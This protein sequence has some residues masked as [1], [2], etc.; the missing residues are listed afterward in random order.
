MS[1]YSRHNFKTMTFVSYKHDQP[2]NMLFDLVVSLVVV[3]VVVVV[4]VKAGQPTKHDP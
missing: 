2:T 4:F 3:L 1:R